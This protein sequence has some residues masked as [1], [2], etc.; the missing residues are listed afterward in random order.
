MYA[1]AQELHKQGVH[2]YSVD[3]KTGMQ[4]LERVITKMKP[5][6]CERQDHEYERHGTQCLIANFSVATGKVVSPTI[7]PTR[8]EN[9]F[10][11]H[12][13]TLID[14]AP[15]DAYIFVVDQLNIH[16]SAGL[17]ELVAG[18]CEP[19][20]A[21]GKKEKS[22]ILKDMESR[23]KFL[24]D[25]SHRIRFVYTPKHASWL[26]QIEIW[27]S[28]LSKRLLK[29]LSTTS[30]EELETKVLDFIDFFNKTMSKPFKWTMSGKVLHA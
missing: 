28:I 8:T 4:A 25:E 29:R 10:V 19:N 21:L 1:D 7:G 9:D 23:K 18:Y 2:V 15:D 27:F 13:K 12:I 17:V 26:N 6:R 16:K 22:G 3:E 14:K 5:G 11:A 30:T 24:E 20:T